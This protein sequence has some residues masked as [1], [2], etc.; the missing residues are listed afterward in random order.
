MDRHSL[1]PLYTEGGPEVLRSP[2]QADSLFHKSYDQW[3]LNLHK[4]QVTLRWEWGGVHLHHCVSLSLYPK[5][6]LWKDTKLM[7]SD[8]VYSK[9]SS[10]Q[11]LNLVCS[12]WSLPYMRPG[13]QWIQPREEMKGN[14]SKTAV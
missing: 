3:T 2:D 8:F 12:L 5:G 13:Q 4:K 9:L 7:Q 14:P 10:F 6:L 1:L 11:A